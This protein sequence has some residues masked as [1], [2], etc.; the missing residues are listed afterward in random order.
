M[1]GT[2]DIERELIEVA[3][4]WADA[5]V[6]NDPERIGSFMTDDWV[7]VSDSGITTRE[8]FLD[9]V[10]SGG[11]THSAMNIASEPRIEAYGNVALF[12]ARMTNTAHFGGQQFDA[13][14]WTTD[15]F[16]KHGDR[17]LCVLSQ[18]T[19]VASESAEL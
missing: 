2:S 14:E 15:V 1:S 17:W 5:I 8:Q 9:F 11:L 13:N 18:I 7:I 19:A 16:T 6:S 4:G 10:V 3:R 12:T